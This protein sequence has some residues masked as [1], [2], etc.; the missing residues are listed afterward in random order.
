MIGYELPLPLVL[1]ALAVLGAFVGRFLNRCITAFPLHDRLMAQLKAATQLRTVCRRCSTRASLTE[2]IPVIGWLL[3]G[4]RC[5][6]CGSR[7]SRSGPLIETLTAALFVLVY[8][9]EIPTGAVAVLSDSG[10]TSPEGPRGPEVIQTLWSPVVWLHLRYAL[11]MLMIC[12]LI[13]ATEIDRR[14]RII[15]DGSTIP[16]MLLAL[17]VSGIAA[18]LYIVPIWFQDASTV[19]ILQPL[20][21]EWLQPLFVPWDPTAFIQASPHLHGFLVSACGALAGAGSVWMVRQIGFLVLKQEAMGFGDVVLMAMIGSVIGWQPVLAVFVFAP[22]L[23]IFAAVIN[24]LA[25][26]DNEIPY[27]P[28]LSLA[29]LLLLLTWP[30]SWPL[31]KRFFDMGPF[32]VLMLVFMV[33]LLAASLQL[34][35]LLKRLFGLGQRP[36]DDDGGWTSADH[37]TYY[38]SERPDE[39]TGQWPTDQWPGSRAGR[40][41]L[42]QHDWKHGR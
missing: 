7:L 15:P 19:R 10:L 31:A 20:M 25:H 36:C 4:G 5:H 18:Q 41:L 16:V 27:G 21:P 37:L 3:S 2:R 23:A 1:T 34:V 42:R 11:H 28:F 33:V 38:N 32:L 8:W 35:Q 29:T 9:F 13:V 40:G 14:L 12:G 6:A 22:M 24:W 30:S 39:Q 26:R 17:V